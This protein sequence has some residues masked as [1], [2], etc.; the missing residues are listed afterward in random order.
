M[1]W[2]QFS[3]QDSGFAAFRVRTRASGNGGESSPD[4]PNRELEC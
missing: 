1:F 3:V 4:A 2:V